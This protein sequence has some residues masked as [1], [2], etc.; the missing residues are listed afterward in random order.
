MSSTFICA[1]HTAPREG[2]VLSAGH[3]LCCPFSVLLKA[4]LEVSKMNQ[5]NP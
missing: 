1:N 4:G 3:R 2:V 5:K